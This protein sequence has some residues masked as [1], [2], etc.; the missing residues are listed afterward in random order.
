MVY[1][2]TVLILI[3]LATLLFIAG[4][5]MNFL[6]L[7]HNNLTPEGHLDYMKPGWFYKVQFRF[8]GIDPERL[9]EAGRASLRGAIWNER[10]AFV[11]M[12]VGMILC[13]SLL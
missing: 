12:I 5:W 6:R 1:L 10:M 3:W 2:A 13:A 11:W 8:S 7:I 4:R 9:T